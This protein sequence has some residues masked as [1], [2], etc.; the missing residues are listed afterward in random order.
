MS[1]F[2]QVG[3]GSIAQYPLERVRRWRAISNRLENGERIT[4]P[5]YGTAEILWDLSYEDLN[6]AEAGQIRG[7]FDSVFGEAGIFTFIDP[8][9]NLL[10]WSEDLTRGDWQRGLLTVS[11]GISDPRGASNASRVFNGAAAGQGLTQSLAIRGELVAC[12]SA[13]VRSDSITVATMRRDGHQSSYAIGPAWKRI[14]VTGAGTPGLADSTFTLVLEPGQTI[15]VWGMQVE[16]QPVPSVYKVSAVQTGI[17]PETRFAA[18]ELTVVS[19]GPGR[20]SCRL[21]LLSRVQE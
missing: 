18:P 15:D 4:L 13:W 21:R 3:A 2:P 16:A 19:T 7:L 11:A 9:V 5:D 17:Y 10:G 8:L 20:S 12:F 6:N 1:W 14:Y